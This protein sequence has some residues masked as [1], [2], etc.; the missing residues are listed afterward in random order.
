MIFKTN[1]QNKRVIYTKGTEVPAD[2]D[3]AILET[4][5]A[6]GSVGE[7][8]EVVVEETATETTEDE[9]TEKPSTRM[10]K[11]ELITLAQAK[12]FEVDE[13]MSKS[14]IVALLSE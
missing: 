14:D 6:N 12:G 11:E 1:V 4:L 2:F 13:T 10:K 7:V 9:G 3:E 5:I 8:E